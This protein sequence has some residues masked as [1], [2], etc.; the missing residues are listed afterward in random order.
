[1]L[2]GGMMSWFRRQKYY[3]YVLTITENGKFGTFFGK[4][5]CTGNRFEVCNEL[6]QSACKST[7]FDPNNTYVV[8][9]SLDPDKT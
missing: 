1:M 4:V 8:H 7:G 3:H 6:F 2:F 5:I 9:W